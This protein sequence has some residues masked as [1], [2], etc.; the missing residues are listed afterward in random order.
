MGVLTGAIAIVRVSGTVIGRMRTIRVNENLGRGSVSGIGTIFELE[1]PVLQHRGTV[2]CDFY[3][4][5]FTISPITNAIRRDVQTNQQF[6]DQ[7]CLLEGGVQV[8]IF[9][10]ISDVLDPNT[11]LVIPDVQP[12]ATITRV[13]IDSEGFDIAEGS[14]AGRN[15]TFRF[16]DPILRRQ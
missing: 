2:T 7:L 3:E 10:K 15:Q 13:L 16:L 5:D 9:K 14:I 4:V 1:A 8:D 6:Q 11:G 12:Y